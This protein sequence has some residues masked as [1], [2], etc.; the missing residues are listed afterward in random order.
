MVC[1]FR[2]FTGGKKGKEALEYVLENS[3]ITKLGD[4]K[5]LVAEGP[6]A[7][8]N[9]DDPFIYFMM[10]TKDL[11]K[12]YAAKVKDLVDVNLFILRN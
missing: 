3:K 12:E 1:F 2:K 5:E 7:I 4:L 6:D 8:L 11:T 9:S 10:S